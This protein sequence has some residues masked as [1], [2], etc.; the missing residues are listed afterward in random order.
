M[1]SSIALRHFA[2]VARC[3]SLR[4]A[5]DRLF[6]A[7][8]AIS[9]QLALLEEE[10]GLP[11]FERG[12]G[13][14][15]MRL[16]PA[17]EVLMNLVRKLEAEEENTR[18]AMH[19]LKHPQREVIRMGV[20]ESQT[21]EFMPIFLTDFRRRHP[22]VDFDVRLATSTRLMELLREDELDVALVFNALMLPGVRAVYERPLKTCLLVAHDHPLAQRAKVRLEDCAGYPMALPDA[23]L[24][25][26]RVNDETFVRAGI[27]PDRALV[28]NSY[29][30]LRSTCAA[31]MAVAV[32]S[33][34]LSHRAAEERALR[35]LPLVD[36][37]PRTFGAFLKQGRLLTPTACTF[38]D[39]LVGV[40]R[41]VEAEPAPAPAAR[42]SRKGNKP[43]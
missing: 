28:S 10:F 7:G 25:L 42:R 11:L 37:R 26:M 23:S 20:P 18:A 19:A 8:S 41:E 36:A 3:G 22:E 6:V 30:L 17:G 13:K 5:S 4:L 29:E 39:E 16:T 21:Q 2:E 15:S 38:V 14:T 12:R 40:L 24:D 35:Y 34:P 43:L 27:R 9:R 32:L 1:L 31:G 33:E